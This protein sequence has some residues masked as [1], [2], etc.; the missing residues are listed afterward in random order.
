[1]SRTDAAGRFR[2]AA[3]FIDER[4]PRVEQ[5]VAYE[6][7]HAALDHGDLLGSDLPSSPDEAA[8]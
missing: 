7:E 1:M 4:Q 6:V 2:G 5:S 3:A 8:T